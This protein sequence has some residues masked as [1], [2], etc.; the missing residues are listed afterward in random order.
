MKRVEVAHGRCRAGG[1]P[2]SDRRG[3]NVQFS[4]DLGRAAIFW[5]DVGEGRSGRP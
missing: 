2:G 1:R 3:V 5:S 4:A